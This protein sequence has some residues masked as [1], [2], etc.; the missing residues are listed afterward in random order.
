MMYIYLI[1]LEFGTVWPAQ[2]IFPIF[3]PQE[4]IIDFSWDFVIKCFDEEVLKMGSNFGSIIPGPLSPGPPQCSAPWPHLCSTQRW[5][6]R[7]RPTVHQGLS[8][9]VPTGDHGA[10]NENCHSPKRRGCTAEVVAQSQ[11]SVHPGWVVRDWADCLPPWHYGSKSAGTSSC[12]PAL[13]LQPQ[14]NTFS[15]KSIW[16]LWPEYHA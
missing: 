10:S 6:A 2:K 1:K 11:A 8:C 12:N 4:A 9:W 3:N 7:R 16:M 13:V 14:P 5:V 15:E